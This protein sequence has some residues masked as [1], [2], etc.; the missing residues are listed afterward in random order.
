MIGVNVCQKAENV[1]L[2]NM[3]I[4]IYTLDSNLKF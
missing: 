3:H 4:Y 2:N 1:L